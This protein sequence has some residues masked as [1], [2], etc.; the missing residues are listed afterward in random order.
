[1]D[2]YSEFCPLL[3]AASEKKAKKN[4]AERG[5]VLMGVLKWHTDD[6]YAEDYDG[7]AGSKTGLRPLDPRWLDA[8]VEA[9][10]VELVCTLAKPGHKG[11]NEFLSEQIVKPKDLRESYTILR[12]MARIGHPGATDAV[13]DALKSQA[14]G[15]HYYASY[16]FSEFVADLPRSSLPRLEELLPSLPDKFVDGLMDAMLALKN[17]PE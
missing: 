12:T 16:Y 17:K 3:K 5:E 14:K 11:V 1:M 2:F 15:T 7:R 8:A 10:S 6:D 4:V 13:I 9:G